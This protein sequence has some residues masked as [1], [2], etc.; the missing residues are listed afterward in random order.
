MLSVQIASDLHLESFPSG[1]I[2]NTK[3][4]EILV[5]SAKYLILAGD[6]FPHHLFLSQDKRVKVF[7][8]YIKENFSYTY[9]V[10]GNHYYYFGSYLNKFMRVFEDYKLKI[11]N[12][13]TE[14]IEGVN[15]FFTDL[16]SKPSPNDWFIT[17]HL[18]DFKRIYNDSNQLISYLDYIQMHE[19]SLTHLETYLKTQPNAVVVSHHLPSYFCIG[20][21]YKGDKANCGFA[22]N[23]DYLFSKYS[24]QYWVQ[25][26]SH[27]SWRGEILNTFLIRNPLGYFQEVNLEYK[28]DLIIYLN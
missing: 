17:K 6:I 22:S 15:I 1:E 9:M 16:W 4:P 24:I 5:P 3:L 8:N 14:D 28:N 11:I 26:H 27:E 23:L 20:E 7:L 13:L 12:N 19:E 21:R 10:P 18:L 25:G 2:L